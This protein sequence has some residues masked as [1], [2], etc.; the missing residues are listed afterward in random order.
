MYFYIKRLLEPHDVATLVGKNQMAKNK[1]F[2]RIFA[3]L[4][5]LTA[6]LVYKENKF[7]YTPKIYLAIL[8]LYCINEFISFISAVKN[9]MFF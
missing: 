3:K 8:I 1:F 5:M 6:L 7:C 2:A 4:T 9:R